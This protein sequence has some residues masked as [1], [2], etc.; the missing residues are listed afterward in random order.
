MVEIGQEWTG[1]VRDEAMLDHCL[2]QNIATRG[3][4]DLKRPQKTPRSPG[5]ASRDFA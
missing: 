5:R 1:A 3:R 2:G 4:A